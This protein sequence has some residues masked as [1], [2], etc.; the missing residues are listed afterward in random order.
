MVVTL[1]RR[2][3]PAVSLCAGALLALLALWRPGYVPERIAAVTAPAHSGLRPVYSARTQEKVAALTFD[4]SWGKEQWPRVL[5]ILKAEGVRATFF[6][7]G[8]WAQ[9]T[10]EAVQRI[11]ADGHELASHGQRHD[12]FSRLGRLG[13]AENIQA[14]HKILKDLSGQEPRLVRPPNGDFNAVSLQAARDLGYETVLWSVD[15]LDWKNPGAA[16][17]VQRV[18]GLAH[19]GAI[20]LMHA[21]DS[22]R[23]IHAAL[24]A[25]ISGLRQ[26][27][28][29][30]VTAGALLARYGPDPA[31]CIRVPG[32]KH[33]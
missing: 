8:P 31:G 33:C 26:Q 23:Q 11:V 4:I 27:G 12:N 5:A 29:Q 6:L 32:R 10:P 20:I 16:A 3:W 14:A 19:P 24:P 17:M 25:I 13:T 15:S 30:L 18:L 9:A 7:S 28:Y 22:S 2:P 1:T 21:S